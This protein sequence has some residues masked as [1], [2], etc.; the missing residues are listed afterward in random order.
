MVVIYGHSI[1]KLNEVIGHF[2]FK[3]RFATNLLSD[4]PL[5]VTEGTLKLIVV[6][7]WN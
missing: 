6:K 4:L 1:V 3:A 5:P 7:M 2:I